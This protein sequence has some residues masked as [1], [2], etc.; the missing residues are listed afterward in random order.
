MNRRKFAK[1][2]L[3]G[4]VLA[5]VGT[6]GGGLLSA[7]SNKQSEIMIKTSIPLPIQVVIDDVGWW[8]GKDG[9]S[10][11][12]PF[13]TGIDRNHVV[14]DYQAIIDLG[15]ALGIRPQAA[16]VMGEWDT[17]N[18]LRK[19]PHSTW[20]GEK[21]DNSQWVGPWLEEASDLINANKEHFEITVHGLGHEWWDDGKFTRAEWADDEGIMRPKEILEQ[22][23]DAYAEIMHQNNLGELPKSFVPNAFRHSFGVTKGN[24]ISLAE[25]IKSRGFTYINTPFSSMFN[26][27]GAQY[28][29]FGVDSGVM[30][31]D[32]GSDLLD[33]DVIGT[34]PEGVIKGS[35]CGLHWPNLLHEDPERNS[36]IVEAWVALL[37]PYNGKQN[38]MLAK[39]SLIFQKQL[40]HYE[41]T[42][43]EVKED[44]IKLDFTDLRNLGTVVT[45]DELTV[46]ISSNKA[47]NFT[48]DTIAINSVTVEN[49]D[50]S[51]LYR[52]DLKLRDQ[53]NAT[54]SFA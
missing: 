15:K 16:M 22:H 20:M 7:C 2:S 46:K 6:A 28:E 37:A 4:I 32:R 29:L 12:E 1:N 14:A 42:K 13:R 43:M 17:Q 51:L 21:W 30:T 10:Y 38:T 19:V 52:L 23:L 53:M 3:K 48:S 36:E 5:T 8:S 45:N 27:E 49:R 31:V 47:L 34:K 24:D 54:I 44:E 40:A 9:S 35:T 41:A 50:E 18:I 39:N 26:R 33:W 25:L 11:Q